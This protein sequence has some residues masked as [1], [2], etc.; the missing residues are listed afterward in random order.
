[1]CDVSFVGQWKLEALITSRAQRLRQIL[2]RVQVHARV[3]GAEC[4]TMRAVDVLV[5]WDARSHDQFKCR[6][7]VPTLRMVQY[8]LLLVE[9]KHS[10]Q[11]RHWWKESS[12]C[13]GSCPVLSINHSTRG[14]SSKKSELDIPWSGP[15]YWFS[16]VR[17]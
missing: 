12:C 10:Q 17:P 14:P 5:R 2:G 7:F 1:M 15:Y 4:S 6:S 9:K 3:T 8:M 16:S 11:R 13:V